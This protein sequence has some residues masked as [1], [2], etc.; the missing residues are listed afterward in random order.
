QFFH[1]M[2]PGPKLQENCHP[3]LEFFFQRVKPVANRALQ[4]RV[5]HVPNGDRGIWILKAASGVEPEVW[6]IRSKPLHKR[7]NRIGIRLYSTVSVQSGYYAYYQQ[8]E[9]NAYWH[10]EQQ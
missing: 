4:Y 10:E 2:L 9:Y 7:L 5:A 1:K 3:N 6:K 8:S